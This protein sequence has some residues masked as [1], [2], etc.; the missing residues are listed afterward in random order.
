M[1]SLVLGGAASGKS[2][3]A[4]EHVLRLDGR[5]IYLATMLPEG[6]EARARVE[7]HRQLRAGKGFETLERATD[8]AGLALP[9]DANVLLEDLGNL[10]ANELFSPEGGGAAALRGGLEALRMQCRH[11]TVVSSEVFSGGADYGAS[12]LAYLRELAR[13]NRLLAAEAE[14]VAEIVCGCANVLKGGKG[15]C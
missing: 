7:R 1:L 4:E 3:W 6:E 12:T 15:L 10:L 13:L 5:R 9:A 8:L 14:L 11:L 2:A